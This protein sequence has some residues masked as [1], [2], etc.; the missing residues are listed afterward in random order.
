MHSVDCLE[1]SK[2]AIFMQLGFSVSNW[3][4]VQLNTNLLKQGHKYLYTNANG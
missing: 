2:E 1:A 4:K 3:Q